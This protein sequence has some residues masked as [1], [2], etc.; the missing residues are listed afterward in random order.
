MEGLKTLK[1]RFYSRVGQSERSKSRWL[2]DRFGSPPGVDFEI[3]KRRGHGRPLAVD[4]NDQSTW[5]NEFSQKVKID[6]DI[7]EDVATIHERSIGNEL[8]GHQAR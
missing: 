5:L 2:A 8:L 6:E 3:A 1:G 7:V 4:Q